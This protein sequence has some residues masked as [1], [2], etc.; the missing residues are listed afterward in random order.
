MN[1]TIDYPLNELFETLQGEGFFTGVPAIFVRLQGCPVGCSWCDTQHTWALNLADEVDDLALVMAKSAADSRYCRLTAAALL[2]ECQQRGY[3]ARHLVITGGEPCLYDLRPL[4]TLFADAGF[5]VQVETS[6]TFE[7]RVDARAWVTV[8]PKVNMAGG[9]PVLVSALER[10]DE[11]KHPVAREAHIAE[12]DALLAQLAD[13][14]ASKQICLQPI[15][16]QPRATAL[17]IRTCI[18]RNWRLSAQLHKY[19]AIP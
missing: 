15:S 1:S 2:A 12:L 16:Q 10:A 13:G 5:Q 3:R 17:A 7:V 4:S 14:G 11:I 9:Y 8:S 18:E 6:G 19:L